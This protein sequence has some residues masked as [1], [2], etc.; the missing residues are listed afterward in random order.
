MVAAAR[1]FGLM[2]ENFLTARGMQIGSA[3]EVMLLSLADA[4]LGGLRIDRKAPQR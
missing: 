4:G 1:A 2:P 3:L